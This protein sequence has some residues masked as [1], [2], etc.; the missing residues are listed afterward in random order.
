MICSEKVKRISGHFHGLA[1]L[2]IAIFS[3][4]QIY[5]LK[6]GHRARYWIPLGITLMMVLRLPNVICIALKDWHG[7]YVVTGSIIALISNAYITHLMIE[8]EK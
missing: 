8:N 3:G 2:L 1:V 7:W 4:I 5:E 6:A